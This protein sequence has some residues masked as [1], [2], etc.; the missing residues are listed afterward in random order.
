MLRYEFSKREMYYTVVCSSFRFVSS[1]RYIHG[2]RYMKSGGILGRGFSASRDCDLCFPCVD[3]IRIN[4]P[5]LAHCFDNSCD[6]SL[7]NTLSIH[8]IFCGDAHVYYSSSTH[9]GNTL[10]PSRVSEFVYLSVRWTPLLVTR[11]ILTRGSILNTLRF[12]IR[13]S[14]SIKRTLYL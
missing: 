3:S 12:P 2:Q 10:N 5:L 4:L 14:T 1:Q 13:Y 8:L 9:R 6:R 11:T 7:V